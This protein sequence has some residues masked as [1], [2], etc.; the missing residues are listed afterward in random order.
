VCILLIAELVR[1]DY[2]AEND[3]KITTLSLKPSINDPTKVAE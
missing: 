3:E 2:D 1:R